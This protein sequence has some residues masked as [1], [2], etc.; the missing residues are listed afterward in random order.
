[1]NQVMTEVIV[2]QPLVSPGLLWIFTQFL[3]A[4]VFYGGF[5]SDDNDDPPTPPPVQK[6]VTQ[7]FKILGFFCMLLLL[8]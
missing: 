8:M 4:P 6:V 5:W 3:P 2:E 7:I 1:M